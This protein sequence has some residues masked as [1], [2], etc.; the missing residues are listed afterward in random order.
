[1]AEVLNDIIA[2]R[3]K[4]NGDR[5]MK[6]FACPS[7]EQSMTTCLKH[8]GVTMSTLAS[9]APYQ[10]ST[11]ISIRKSTTHRDLNGDGNN[12]QDMERGSAR[13]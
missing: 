11:Q 9:S 5:E 7:V 8:A 6:E 2:S 13:E 4:G 10:R 3:G 1:M 12:V